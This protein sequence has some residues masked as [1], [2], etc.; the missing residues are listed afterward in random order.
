MRFPIAAAL[1]IVAS[2][3]QAQTEGDPGTIV[4]N[5]P[6]GPMIATQEALE[7]AKRQGLTSITVKLENVA[8]VQDEELLDLIEAEIETL[9]AERGMGAGSISFQRCPMS[10]QQQ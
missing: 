2:A 6:D 9:A 1:L 3:A 8:Q 10:C 7:R 4:V 5:A